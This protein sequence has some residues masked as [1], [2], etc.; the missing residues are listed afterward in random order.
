MMKILFAL[1]DMSKQHLVH[2]LVFDHHQ[3]MVDVEV[4][5]VVMV[6]YVQDCMVPLPLVAES[7]MDVNA[8]NTKADSL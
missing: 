8:R 1:P 7:S 6:K 2:N 3:A 5:A 4:E